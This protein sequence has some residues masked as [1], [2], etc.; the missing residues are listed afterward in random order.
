MSLGS[1]RLFRKLAMFVLAAVACALSLPSS[2][3]ATGVAGEVVEFYNAGLQHYFISA[4]PAETAV[5]DGGAFGGVW[6]RTGSAFS[7]W[8][9]AGAPA[10]TVPVCR[11]FGTDRYRTNGSR[12]GPNSHFYTANPAECAFVKTGYQSVANDGIS[13]PAWTFEANAFAVKLPAGGACPA[14]TQSL[15]RSYNN[16]M[17][18]DP[19]HRYS[20]NADLLQ[21]MAGWVFEGLVMCVPQEPMA[22]VYVAKLP[23]APE[24][25]GAPCSN[26]AAWQA[27][28]SKITAITAQADALL[29]QSFPA[30]S[31]S[32]YLS[33]EFSAGDTMMAARK[34]W[35]YPLV[36]AECASWQGKYIAAIRTTL[37][38]LAAQPAWAGPAT[39]PT[40]EGINHG[41]WHQDLLSTALAH[42]LAQALYLLGDRV[43]ADTRAL[44][45]AALETRVFQP[46]RRTLVDGYN[47]WWLTVSHNWNAV[48]L[49]DIVGAALAVIPS[50]QDR[51]NFAA[52]G[53]QYI[54]SFVAPF[55]ESGF[56]QEGP[57]YWTYGVKHFAVLRH[58]LHESSAGAVDLFK[59]AKPRA[60]SLY[61]ARIEM[62]PQGAVAPFGDSYV[63]TTVDAQTRAYLAAAYGNSGSWPGN[64]QVRVNPW[65]LNDMPL[66]EASM[67]LTESVPAA[68]GFESGDFGWPGLRSYFSDVGVLVTR[69]PTTEVNALAATIK[70]AGNANHSHDDIGS[71]SI[72]LKGQIVAGDVGRGDYTGRTFSAQRREVK[73][74]NSW[75]HPVPVVGGRQQVDATG[76]VNTV[77][78]TS[79]T[80][81][82]DD[83][84]INLAPAYAL[85]SGWS[86]VRRL[87]NDRVN[88]VIVVQDEFSGFSAAQ[89]FEVPITTT[90][91]WTQLAPDRLRLT[92]D[93]Q[94]E[95]MVEASAAFGIV[96]EQVTED[97]LTFQRIA[98]RL[99]TA[100]TNGWVRV[101][102]SR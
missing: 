30:W 62:T 45:T 52:V 26:R 58:R 63:G 94:V 88:R 24:G 98:I 64:A 102:F 36:L 71:Y 60:F 27:T 23:S 29:S 56:G 101:T 93:E 8:N 6:K 5:L 66:V 81:A 51:A 4:D 41:A 49:A 75:G 69:S 39:D 43:D 11:F 28:G 7:A 22:A 67:L 76:A 59:A 79:F 68:T 42:E 19:N 13:Y 46:V 90:G 47:S 77:Q 70:S 12:I 99:N 82:V 96:G 54:Q 53:Q 25:T 14:G 21:L 44:V 48:M 83:I 3:K 15:Y 73:W 37:R 74:I 17:L 20:T 89:S 65:Y 72:A 86:L 33:S 16:G 84:A 78:S 92:R 31:T 91:T 100:A 50:R 87:R 80:D 40:M 85:P 34:A 57:A 35:L 10:G 2:V 1:V 95:A 18:G 55:P 61:S 32:V 9:F 38:E 97:G